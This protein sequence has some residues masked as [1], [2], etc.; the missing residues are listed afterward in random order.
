MNFTSRKTKA[1]IDI[2]VDCI[3]TTIFYDE[4]NRIIGTIEQLTDILSEL[5]DMIDQDLIIN[6]LERD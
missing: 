1:F 3:E 4:K 5:H 2:K 6:I